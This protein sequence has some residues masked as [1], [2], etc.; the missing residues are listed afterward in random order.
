M[1][2][3]GPTDRTVSSYLLMLIFVSLDK[4]D[5][6]TED[7]PFVQKLRGI[8]LKIESSLRGYLQSIEL[9]Y[10]DSY[11]SCMYKLDTLHHVHSL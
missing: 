8:K 10:K 4:T 11:D 7:E 1:I 5:L 6:Y 9:S 2:S 3:R